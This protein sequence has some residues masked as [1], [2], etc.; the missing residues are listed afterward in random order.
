MNLGHLA[1]KVLSIFQDDCVQR[2]QEALTLHG[3]R[4]RYQHLPGF[5]DGRGDFPVTHQQPG[6][7]DLLPGMQMEMLLL[8][9]DL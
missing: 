8:L 1:R 6:L 5:W 9:R 7:T 4:M 2:Y 3:S